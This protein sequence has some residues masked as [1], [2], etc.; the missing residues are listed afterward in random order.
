MGKINLGMKNKHLKVDRYLGGI[1]PCTFWVHKELKSLP[2]LG[3]RD[4]IS[5]K[6]RRDRKSSSSFLVFIGLIKTVSAQLRW[7]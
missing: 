7:V 2:E 4:P 3:L 6:S 1:G 5:P